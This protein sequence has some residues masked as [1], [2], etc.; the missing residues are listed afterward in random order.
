MQDV[1]V[2]VS[3]HIHTLLLSKSTRTTVTSWSIDRVMGLAYPS[4]TGTATSTTTMTPTTAPSAA[5]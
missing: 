2:T 4:T 3:D 1:G 5:T